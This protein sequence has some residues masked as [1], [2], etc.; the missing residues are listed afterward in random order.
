MQAASNLGSMLTGFIASM[1]I[2]L[3]ARTDYLVV[4]RLLIGVN[5]N[6]RWNEVSSSNGVAPRIF[7]TVGFGGMGKA[8]KADGLELD[9]ITKGVFLVSNGDPLP[10]G[11]LY[12]GHISRPRPVTI[13]SNTNKTY[14]NVLSTFLLAHKIKTK[15]R[16][17]KL[18]SADLDGDGTREVIIEASSR[19]DVHTEHMEGSIEGD[20]SLVMIRYVRRGKAAT[21]IIGFEHPKPYSM[22]YRET[23]RAV[24]DFD[25]DGNMEIVESSDYYEG[26]GSALY[27]FSRGRL[28]RLVSAGAGV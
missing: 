23:L 1:V 7:N 24:A 28:T 17:T 6:G 9:D 8:Y 21:Q 19:D 14:L 3:P 25:G 10:E 15:A 13:V 16:I 26:G 12:S 18:I 11:V 22:M 4:D 5:R 20:Y 27:R 2:G